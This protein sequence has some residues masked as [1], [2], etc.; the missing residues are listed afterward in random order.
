MLLVYFGI[1]RLFS[2]L[3]R[4]GVKILV[5]HGIV[6][7]DLPE[8]LNCEG[9]H[10]GLRSFERHITYLKKHYRVMALNDLLRHLKNGGPL[11]EYG[12]VL[13]FDDGYKNNYE[14]LKEIILKYK[15]SAGIFL[16]TDYIGTQELLW[17]DRLELAFFKSDRKSINSTQAIGLGKIEW[18]SDSEKMQKY[19]ILKNHLKKI[20]HDRLA[21]VLKNLFSELSFA[22][23]CVQGSDTAYTCLLNWEEVKELCRYGVHFGSHT[24]R[25]EILT[26]LSESMVK[27]TLEKSFLSVKDFSKDGGVPFAYPNGNFNEQTKKAVAEAGYNCALTTAHGFNSKADDLYALKRNEIGNRGDIHIF[28]ATLSGALDF[29]KS[30]VRFTKR[31]ECTY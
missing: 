20:P 14:S 21:E 2:F 19:V 23:V 27:D 9:L 31:Q 7:Q 5:Y 10:L 6:K 24:C 25:H 26:A 15:I 8:G 1:C 16:V 3:N 17:L 29:I 22:E 11:P 12:V 13:T 28:I 18:K 4:K 30:L